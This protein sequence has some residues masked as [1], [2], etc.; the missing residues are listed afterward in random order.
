MET[1]IKLCKVMAASDSRCGSENWVL[2]EKDNIR[3]TL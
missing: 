3:K 2:T 1:Q